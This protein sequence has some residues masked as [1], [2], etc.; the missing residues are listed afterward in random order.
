MVQFVFY[1]CKHFQPDSVGMQSL[2]E[3]NDYCVPVELKL[4]Q[5]IVDLSDMF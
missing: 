4:E 3:C 1:L 5:P 2:I